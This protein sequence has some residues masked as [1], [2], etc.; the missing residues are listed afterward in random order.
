M[1]VIACRVTKKGY[2]IAAD[3]ITVRGWTQSKGKNTNHSKL[4]KVNGM[5][6]GSVGSAEEASLFQL[7]LSTRKPALETEAAI[8]ELLS[9]FSRWK[10][11]NVRNTDIRNSYILGLD[12]SVFAIEGWLVEKI[13]T[14]E[15]IGAGMDFALAA[16]HL[17]HSSK[18][19]V[20]TAIELSIVCENPVQVI[21]RRFKC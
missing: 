2:E 18:K 12:T 19:A 10:D 1:S 5:Y 9:D 8:L 3:S 7:Y 20:E 17:G 6:L 11:E 15:A 4:I 14:F 16:L 13:I 21:K